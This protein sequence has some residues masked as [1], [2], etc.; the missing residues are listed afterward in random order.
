MSLI[1]EALRK[2]E[3]ERR[4]GQ[5]PDL[6]AELPPPPPHGGRRIP[7][8]AWLALGSVALLAAAWLWTEAPRHAAP[9]TDASASAAV[10]MVPQPGNADVLPQASGESVTG[11]ATRTRFPP[12]DRIAPAPQAE[13]ALEAGRQPPPATQAVAP[14][15]QPTPAPTP[16]HAPQPRPLAQAARTATAGDSPQRMPTVAE[17]SPEERRQLPALKFSMHMWNE[18]PEQRFVILDGTR[19]GEG[20]R[21]GPAVVAAIDLDGVRLDLN[22]R[23]VRLPL[24]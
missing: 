24:R 12:V 8:G 21:V 15:T 20:D 9:A 7:G 2:S 4:R 16:A 22:G 11:V 19:Y 6:A 23:A 14:M 18:D 3:A 13:A 17:L 1:L 10:A 5:A